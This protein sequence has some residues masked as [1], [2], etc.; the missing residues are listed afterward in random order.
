MDHLQGLGQRVDGRPDDWFQLEPDP[1]LPANIRDVCNIAGGYLQYFTPG[2][3]GYPAKGHQL[4]GREADHLGC[5]AKA[6]SFFQELL[7][8][9]R[10]K[11]IDVLQGI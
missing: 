6:L 11:T 7:T 4:D 8:L 3:A 1:M 9:G 2:A 5:L 10:A